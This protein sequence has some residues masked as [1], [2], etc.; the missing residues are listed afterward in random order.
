MCDRR[1]TRTHVLPTQCPPREGGN[2]FEKHGAQLDLAS[3]RHSAPPREGGNRF[4]LTAQLEPPSCVPTRARRRASS[5][6][7]RAS[8]NRRRASS[9]R[10]RA[11]VG[12]SRE[13]LRV[14]QA[15][16]KRDPS[17]LRQQRCPRSAPTAIALAGR[18]GRA[19]R[20]PVPETPARSVVAPGFES[21]RARLA[22]WPVRFETTVRPLR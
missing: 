18:D 3:C 22:T 17:V 20:P 14:P 19:L 5:N 10:R 8:S 11:A 13:V 1:A 6:R 12:P 7:R 16:P 21:R 15:C 4:E 9:N 2:K